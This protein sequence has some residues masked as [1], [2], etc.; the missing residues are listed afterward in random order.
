M[1]DT[2]PPSNPQS[3]VWHRL[4][5]DAA[6]AAL[7]STPKGLT[8][9]DAAGR[10]A[11]HG[12]N[13]LE[14]RGGKHPAAILWE[15]LTAVM[16][17][18][19]IAAAV[20]SFFLGKYLEAGAILA[21][22]VLFALL[23]FLQEYR[24]ERAMQALKRLSVPSV[25]VL[26]DGAVVLLP[27]PELVPGDVVLVEAG[28]LMPA[29]VRFLKSA[30][31]RVQEA[32]LTGESEAVEKDAHAT[33][34]EE[35]ALG[36]R[37]NLGFMGTL[38]AYGRGTAVVI[39]TGM[40]T[41]LGRIAELL[42][43]VPSEATP[44]QRRLDGVGKQL[45]LGGVAVALLVAALGILLG[46]QLAEMIL[47][48]ISVA[49]AVIPEGLPAV[50]TVTLALGAQRMLKREALIRKLPAVE[51][52]GSVTAVCSDKT[53]TLTQNLMTVTS[54]SADS[55]SLTLDTG[56]DA[57]EASGA[58]RLVLAAG[59]LCNDAQH[60]KDG[61]DLVGDPTETALVV[62]ARRAG[63]SKSV[64]EAAQPRVAEL[65]FD[66]SRK[67]MTTVHRRPEEGDAG[68]P[69]LWGPDGLA[70]G[71]AHVAVTKGATDSVLDACTH[72]WVE[73]GI[74]PLDDEGRQRLLN[75]TAVLAKDGMRVLAF[76]LRPL[77]ALE[78]DGDLEKELIFVGVAGMIDPP[79][80]E[81]RAVVARARHAGIRVIMITGDH[82]LT[83]NA[84]ARDL[85]IAD[86][87][88]FLTGVELARLDDAELRRAVTQMAVF[89]RVSPEHKLRIVE[90]LQAEGKIVAMTG[91]GVNDAPA[92]KRANI[93]VAMGI[94]GTDVSKEA[95]DMVLR[96]DNFATIVAAVEEGRVIYDNLR[97]FVKFVVAGNIG[98]VLVML[99]WP[100]PF[101]LVAQPLVAAVAL[102][103]LQLLWLN[104][105]TDG[106][107]GLG[108]GF[109]R[110]ER[111]VM[112]RPPNSPSAGIFSGGMGWQAV[113][114]GL[115][116]GAFALVVGAAY[117]LAGRDDWQT[118]LFT[119]LAFLQVFQAFGTRSTHESLVT[120]GAFTN[121][122][123]S[124][125]A[126]GVVALQLIALYTPLAAFLGVVPLPAVDLAYSVLVGASLLVALEVEKAWMRTRRL[127]PAK[128][129]S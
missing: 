107:L 84:I 13:E 106:L 64:L 36:D 32:A 119:T 16:V 47:T 17:L 108:M 86:D 116:I 128:A 61:T 93:G 109:E 60:G 111:D 5:T 76:A 97:R 101:L 73:G 113:W 20:L 22:V 43:Q 41:E 127:A 103:P 95:S 48:A 89:A 98:K 37:R 55:R 125:I 62:A 122:A 38:V 8:S 52:L 91:E 94:T 19:L 25:R 123:L 96:D 7:D 35:A 58:L 14:D 85:G 56:E 112:D 46:E 6:L 72:Q 105:L 77:E 79:R 114:T 87:E 34:P 66:S 28:A 69:E 120:Q 81:V 70:G 124:G 21:I 2:S 57:V 50:V 59:A 53:G 110:A 33:F 40:R 4:G 63:L 11:E 30:N 104:L 42:Q 23:G 67:R 65:P 117:A 1:D 82:P 102:L 71:S 9:T 92:L 31:L 74:V 27:A 54:I 129:Q 80:P 10:L 45:A 88:R 118:M 90:S 29:D 24:A 49:V 39:A 26:R 83:A 15:Q 75:T 3:P 115:Y 68:L 51:T 126:V 78:A 121:P 12:R 100:L 44:L 99:L 18:I